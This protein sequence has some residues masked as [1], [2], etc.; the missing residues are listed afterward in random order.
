VDKTAQNGSVLVTQA[1]NY[2]QASLLKNKGCRWG[3]TLY[4]YLSIIRALDLSAKI[5]SLKGL[6]KTYNPDLN[7]V[8]HKKGQETS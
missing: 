3:P 2:S 5:E 8:V 6:I 4:K 7:P 1:K